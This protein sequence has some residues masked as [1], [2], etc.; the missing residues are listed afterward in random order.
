MQFLTK[1]HK[2]VGLCIG[3]QVFLWLLSGLMMSLLNPAKVS[4][5]QWAH[6]VSHETQVLPTGALLDLNELPA[7]QWVDAR[8]IR[9]LMHKGQPV[10]RVTRAGGTT[11]INAIDGSVIAYDKAAAENLARHD[12]S[13]DG[14]ILSIERGIAPDLETRNHNGPYWRVNFSDDVY[15]SLYVSASTGAILERRNSYWRVF[16]VFWML[17]I[18][19]YTGRADF[20]NT[21]IIIVALVAIWLGISGFILLF[22][23]FSWRDF[24]F[25]GKLRQRGEVLVTLIDPA[26]SSPRQVKLKRGANLYLALSAKNVTLPSNCGG[27]GSCGLCRVQVESPDLTVPKAAEKDRIP[28]ILLAQGYRLA[29][30]HDLNSSITLHL[31]EGTIASGQG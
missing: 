28:P 26:L 29:C 4:G 23:S 6:D 15:T 18:M 20:N 14:E 13:G 22:G 21:L 12:Y 17:H 19:D 27:G 9:L 24:N 31:A 2:W 8:N 25:L 16:D 10:Y 11:L 1:L 30:Q 3:I 5:A 7:D